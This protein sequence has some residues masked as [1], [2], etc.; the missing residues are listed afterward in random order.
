[1]IRML[2]TSKRQRR[3]GLTVSLGLPDVGRS[4]TETFNRRKKS[5]EQMAIMVV[6]FTDG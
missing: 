1:M 3:D 4:G 2:Y 6:H 5:M